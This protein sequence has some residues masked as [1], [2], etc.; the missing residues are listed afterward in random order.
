MFQRWIDDFRTESAAVARLSALA[1][2]AGVALIITTA[3]LG[4]A[5]FV[6]VYQQHGAVQACLA[7]AALFF[8][9]T[10]VSAICYWATKRSRRLKAV[11]DAKLAAKSAA[12]K[13]LLS[14]PANIA[15]ALQ[16]ARMIGFKRLLPLIAI[17]GVAMGMMAAV[18]N[19]RSD[20]DKLDDPPM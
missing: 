18:K 10:L 19:D 11:E 13:T 3:F 8:A 16:V 7:A 9:L 12:N 17:G 4:A 2:A 15:I 14:D 20:D 6:M 5:L 1:A